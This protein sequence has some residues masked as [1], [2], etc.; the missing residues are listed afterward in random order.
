[1]EAGAGLY[2]KRNGASGEGKG[3]S[4]LQTHIPRSREIPARG[5]RV[6]QEAPGTPAL[7]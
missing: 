1:M 6:A 7:F 2:N 5:G 4:R 3:G